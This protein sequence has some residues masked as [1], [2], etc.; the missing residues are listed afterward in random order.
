MTDVLIKRRNLDTDQHTSCPDQNITSIPA[1]V[2]TRMSCECEGR[3]RVDVSTSQG[4]PKIASKPP[5][6]RGEA[7][8][9]LL[10]QPS[11]RTNPAD[12]LISDF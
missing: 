7:W 12:S 4:T 10:S 8:N 6:S 11:E 1:Y 5:E 3:V 2:K 9:R